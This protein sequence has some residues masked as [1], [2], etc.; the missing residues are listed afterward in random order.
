MEGEE[1]KTPAVA[2][3]AKGP[4]YMVRLG[5]LGETLTRIPLALLGRFV[6]GAQKFAITRETL[7]DVVK[8]FRKRLAH[9][10]IDYE[11]ASE[12]PEDAGGGPV[13]AAGWIQAVDDA[14]DDHGVLWGQAE[15][16]TRARKMIE[17][18]EYRYFSPVID[19]GA[20]DK[21][22]GEPQGATL[23]SAALTNRPFLEGLPAIAMSD[24]EWANEIGRGDADRGREKTVKIILTDRV[25]GMAR[26]V[27]DDGTEQTL[28]VEGFEPQ[29]KVVRLSDVKRG[30]DGRYDFSKLPH[31]DGVLIAGEILRAMETETVLDDAVKA[32]K[33]LPA[34]RTAFAKMALSDLREVV[35]SMKP[36]VNLKALGTGATEGEA[37]EGAMQVRLSEA[38]KAKIASAKVEY[39]TALRMVLSENPDLEREY[40]AGMRGGK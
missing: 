21:K 12:H 8:N 32:G 23:I 10:V 25:A 24:A 38:V 40:K 31:E 26:V 16:T 15:F 11:H 37:A 9:T 18:K 39:P 1:L 6:K 36:Q 14:P 22:T 35:E 17:E 13:P 29:P 33:I 27:A 19:W 28:T 20:R 7:T 4:R 30:S 3:C 5:D 34:Q 2:M